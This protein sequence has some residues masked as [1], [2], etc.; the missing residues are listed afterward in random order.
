MFLKILKFY[1]NLRFFGM[2]SKICKTASSPVILI[3]VKRHHAFEPFFLLFECYDMVSCIRYRFHC[4]L[5]FFFHPS[6]CRCMH[7][8]LEASK[9]LVK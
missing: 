6:S 5:N 4:C 1:A 7:K 9:I 3:L 2:I 8:L